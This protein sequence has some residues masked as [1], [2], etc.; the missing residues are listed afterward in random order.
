MKNLKKSEKIMILTLVISAVIS[1]YYFFVISP[2]FTERSNLLTSI[3]SLDGNNISDTSLK[4]EILTLDNEIIKLEKEIDKFKDNNAL[5]IIPHKELVEFIGL[6]SKIYD[7]DVKEFKENKDNKNTLS[8][9]S[10]SE[11]SVG[12][13]GEYSNIVEFTNSLYLMRSHFY[14]KDMKLEKIDLIPMTSGV[15]NGDESKKESITLDWFKKY[16]NKIDRLIPPDMKE[17][18]IPEDLKKYDNSV[19]AID[20]IYTKPSYNDETIQL[21]FKL[22]FL[23]SESN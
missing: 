10:S 11:Y 13:Q 3:E 23:D 19:S 9:Y 21:I 22:K 18:I 17:D 14:I 20:S 6:T 15:K 8:G 4:K 7:I 16:S 5:E 12:I 1:S 2:Y